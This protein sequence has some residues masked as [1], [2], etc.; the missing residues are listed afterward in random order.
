MSA[1][2]SNSNTV[3][4]N[5]QTSSCDS[6]MKIYISFN[7]FLKKSYQWKREA[8]LLRQNSISRL[9]INVNIFGFTQSLFSSKYF[10]VLPKCTSLINNGKISCSNRRVLLFKGHNNNGQR[11]IEVH[12]V[13]YYYKCLFVEEMVTILFK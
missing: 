7:V 11:K 6:Q 1:Q 10:P 8:I 2:R 12:G 13:R 3:W 9:D 4:F 5:F